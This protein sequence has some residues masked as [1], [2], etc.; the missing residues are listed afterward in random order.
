MPPP[1]KAYTIEKVRLKNRCLPTLYHGALAPLSQPGKISAKTMSDCSER[2]KQAKGS[3]S[4]MLVGYRRVSSDTSGRP[5]TSNATPCSPLAV[6]RGICVKIR[7]AGRGMIAPDFRR[8]SP[9]CGPAIVWSSGNWT[10]SVLAVA[11]PVH[12][13]HLPGA[14][15]GVLLPDRTERYHHPARDIPVECLWS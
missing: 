2:R 4:D 14:G 3:F 15:R 7:P 6:M 11:S 8:R 9:T 10:D 12:C 13:H 5:R 1:E